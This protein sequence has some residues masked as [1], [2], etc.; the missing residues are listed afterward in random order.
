MGAGIMGLAT[1]WALARS[2]HAVTVL[3]QGPVPNPKGASVDQHRLI[4]HAY[5]AQAGYMRMVSD[6]Y[7]AWDAL[8]SDLGER[9]YVPTGTLVL[10]TTQEG[11]ARQSAAALAAF[12]V[13]VEPL[14]PAD[15]ARRF[16][17]L[18]SE[19]VAT[20]FFVDTGGVLLAEPIVA[21][22]ARHLTAH[23]VAIEAQRRVSAID[24]ARARV[25]LESGGSVEADALV[26]AAGAW[27]L[28]LVPNLAERVT[29]SR[30]VLAYI[31]PPPA[32]RDAWA[33]MPMVLDIAPD[34]GFYLVPPVAGTGLKVGDH[35]FS[36]TGDPDDA[37]EAGEH[38]A[39]A[40]FA[41]CRGRLREF[42][43][44]RLAAAKV[45]YYTVEAQ[46]RFLVER[47]GRTWVVSACSGHAF[48]FGPLL[49]QRLAQTLAGGG[50]PAALARWAAGES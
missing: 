3:E 10:D 47:T 4:R 13:A 31:E 11:W 34:A 25:A 24:A 44:Y 17:L 5:G 28:R 23:G 6:A 49:G 22:L 50:D 14:T 43:R 16:P 33:A 39:R 26:V 15:V 40:V 30:Q 38:E 37:R 12:G 42:D 45:C 20:A 29:P 7:H 41:L 48:K 35:R 46:E 9:L 32:L 2:G 18:E 36:R 19:G 27:V 1:A 8:W 21:A